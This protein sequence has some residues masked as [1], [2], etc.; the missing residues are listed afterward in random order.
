[1]VTSRAGQALRRVQHPF[2][3]RAVSGWVLIFYS[4]LTPKHEDE[5]H[6]M[7]SN[8][9]PTVHDRLLD[10]AVARAAQLRER[11]IDDFFDGVA[12]AARRALRPASRL[13]SSIVRHSRLPRQLEG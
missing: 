13:A 5:R 6:K 7:N 12:A 11:A 1:M 4:S 10:L 9:F 8:Q 2:A 3:C